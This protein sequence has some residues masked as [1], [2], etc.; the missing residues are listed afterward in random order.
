MIRRQGRGAQHN[1]GQVQH[2]EVLSGILSSYIYTYL[3]P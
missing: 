3:L 1:L 2:Q